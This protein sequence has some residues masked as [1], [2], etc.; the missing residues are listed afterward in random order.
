MLA[1]GAIAMAYAIQTDIAFSHMQLALCP[2]GETCKVGNSMER[3]QGQVEAEH[4]SFFTYHEAKH[5][6]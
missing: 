5:P 4:A 6:R 2:Q 1:S 3:T